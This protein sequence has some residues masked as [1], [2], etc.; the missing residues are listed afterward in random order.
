MPSPE[1]SELLESV[2]TGSACTWACRDPAEDPVR[3]P[4]LHPPHRRRRCPR[5][6]AWD[7]SCGGPPTRRCRPTIVTAQSASRRV[8]F[9]NG[10]AGLSREVAWHTGWAWILEP[11]TRRPRCR[12]TSGRAVQPR[13][14]GG[15]DP[16]RGRGPR[17]RR[18]PYRRG[19]RAPGG[20]RAHAHRPRVQ[21]AARRP[22]T[23]R[24]RRHALRR[25]GADG[26]PAARDRRPGH[27]TRGRRARPHRAHAP[28]ELRPVQDRP[29]ARDGAAGGPRSRPGLPAD[30]ARGRGDQLRQPDSA[31]RPARSSRST[32]S[33]AGRSTPRSCARRRPASRSSACPRASSGW[34]GSTSTR[35]SSPTSIRRWTIS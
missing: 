7:P 18:G 30:R 32:T 16:V 17:G 9:S 14:G 13:D 26:P 8:R 22:D 28:R 4:W 5:P 20:E 29:P 21:A 6:S 27:R 10:A 3:L 34:A 19:G 35:P 23:D 31:S 24:R 15:G 12:G 1:P 25:R 2:L 33:A 11:P